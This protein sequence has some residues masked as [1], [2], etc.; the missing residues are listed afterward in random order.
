MNTQFS[1]VWK[2]LGSSRRYRNQFVYAQAGRAFAF[3]IRAIMKR[4]G[5]TQE[6]LAE[7]AGLTQGVISRAADPNYGKLT[8][9]VK[10]KIANGL[11]MAYLGVLLPFSDAVKWFSEIS[12][13]SVQVE[14]FEEEDQAID[15]GSAASNNIGD[16]DIG[17]YKALDGMG[18]DN[19]EVIKKSAFGG[20]RFFI[21]SRSFG[22]SRASLPQKEEQQR[23][24]MAN[25]F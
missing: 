14:T 21:D 12:E 13:D 22:N 20:S 3:Q 16:V 25:A 19:Q 15:L 17:A 6:E 7:R 9:T 18:Q 1:K 10:V 8:T 4:R 11:D 5:I 2:R 23:L 24:E